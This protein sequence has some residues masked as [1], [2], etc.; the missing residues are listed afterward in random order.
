MD[1]CALYLIRDHHS[2]AVKIGISMHPEKRLKQIAVHYSVGRVSIIQATWF[3]TRDQA[4][5]WESNFHRRY[6]IHQSPGQGGR[7]W[8]D[9]S[10]QQIQ[11][12]VEWMEASTNQRAVKVVKVQAEAKKSTEEI[13]VDRRSAFWQGLL[14]SFF[15]GVFP[16]I[17]FY[18]LGQNPVGAFAAP[19]GVGAVAASRVKKQKKLSQAYRLDGKAIADMSLEREYKLMGLWVERTYQLDGLKS[20]VW[21]FPEQTSPEQA[22]LFL[23]GQNDRSLRSLGGI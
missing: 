16:I 13:T 4:R 5:S 10:D 22:Q 2:N 8:F 9:L 18:M 12:F 21:K 7:E 15:T 17:G 6:R 1:K 20:A 14:I 3:T 11:N 23:I 19:A